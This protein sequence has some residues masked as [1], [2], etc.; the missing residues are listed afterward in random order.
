MA[1]CSKGIDF[2]AID[3]EPVKIVILLIT[4]KDKLSQHIKTLANIAKMM[5]DADLREKAGKFKNLGCCFED[6]ERLSNAIGYGKSYPH[7]R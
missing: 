2:D 4:P 6:F 5:G 3:N 7:F 1:I